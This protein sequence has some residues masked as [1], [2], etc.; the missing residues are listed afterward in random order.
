MVNPQCEH[1]DKFCFVCGLFTPPA[2]GRKI[3]RHVEET[4]E[5]H[6]QMA[7]V[8]AWYKPQIICDYCR[9]G[10]QRTPPIIKYTLPMQWLPRSEHS[11]A[12]CYF[13]INNAKTIGFRYATRHTIHYEMVDTVMQTVLRTRKNEEEPVPMDYGEKWGIHILV[14][15]GRIRGLGSSKGCYDNIVIAKF[16]GK[17][18]ADNYEQI[19]ARL[20][21]T[22]KVMGVHMSLKIHFLAHH[23]KFFPDNLGIEFEFTYRNIWKK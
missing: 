1:R 13:C 19:V 8:G 18:R 17:K 15:A 4:F 6:F 9:T 23:L 22:Y 14:G 12:S 10:L 7:F 16:L 20:I 2:H 11:A 5:E 21:E 3:N